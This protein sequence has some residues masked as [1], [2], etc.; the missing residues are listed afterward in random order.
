[1]WKP[2]R[3]WTRQHLNIMSEWRVKRS[4]LHKA[5]VIKQNLEVNIINWSFRSLPVMASLP[6]FDSHHFNHNTP[7]LVTSTSHRS[8]FLINSVSGQ[9][10]FDCSS[11]KLAVENSDQNGNILQ[12][13]WC[14]NAAPR[15]KRGHLRGEPLWN[16]T[17]CVRI[18]S[19]D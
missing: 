9:G 11:L 2:T 1:M 4:I 12:W 17:F 18:F 3:H 16:Q 19:L 6:I 13:G 7:R 10:V 8:S 15:W 5:G 14:E